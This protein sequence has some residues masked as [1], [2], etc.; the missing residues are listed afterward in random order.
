MLELNERLA[1][2][3]AKPLSGPMNSSRRKKGCTSHDS[4][5]LFFQSDVFDRLDFVD[6]DFGS[7]PRDG[8]G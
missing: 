7:V 8:A 4:T 5:F 6:G 3:V 2:W 1:D